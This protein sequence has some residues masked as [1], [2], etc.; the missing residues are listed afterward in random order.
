[1]SNNSF[2]GLTA[3]E[4]ELLTLLAEECAEVI[5]AVAK[6]QRHGLVSYHPDDPEHVSNAGHLHRELGDVRAAMVLLSRVG[7]LHLET[8]PMLAK[9]KLQRLQ[10]YLHHHQIRGFQ[11]TED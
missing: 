7:I 9:S 4:D 11:G 5:Q 8:L 6:I 1:M 3:E 10:P 2:N